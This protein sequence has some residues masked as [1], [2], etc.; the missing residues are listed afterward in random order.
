MKTPIPPEDVAPK[1]FAIKQLSP[2]FKEPP[3][4]IQIEPLA[5]VKPLPAPAPIAMLPLP[6]VMLASVAY[7]MAVLLL[8]VVL[9]GSAPIQVFIRCVCMESARSCLVRH[10]LILV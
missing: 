9:L 4:P 1:I 7:P 6:V 5:V 2:T 3:A 8:P 10:Y